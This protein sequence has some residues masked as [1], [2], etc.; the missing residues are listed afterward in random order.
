MNKA[1]K[2]IVLILSLALVAGL[3]VFFLNYDTDKGFVEQLKN[4][5]LKTPIESKNPHDDNLQSP[6]IEKPD[7]E[8]TEE[9][10]TSRSSII[11]V[12]DLPQNE[13]SNQNIASHSS[14]IPQKPKE[15]W[16]Q[17]SLA[18]AISQTVD[19]CS[20]ENGVYVNYAQPTIPDDYHFSFKIEIFD[21]SGATIDRYVSDAGW[22][23]DKKLYKPEEKVETISMN[24]SDMKN[25]MAFVVVK[26]GDKD[27]IESASVYQMTIN[28]DGSK[29]WNNAVIK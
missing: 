11:L 9:T 23:K 20:D 29:V 22:L 4:F 15:G 14:I 10:T 17:E 27:L 5:S 12:D 6:S 21:Q 28:F 24:V 19:F 13:D 2:I 25:K 7:E 8:T 16:S 26:V 1:I 3:F 18:F